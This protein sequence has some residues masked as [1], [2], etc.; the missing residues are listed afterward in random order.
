MA[1]WKSMGRGDGAGFVRKNLLSQGVWSSLAT[2][3][4]VSD[5]RIVGIISGS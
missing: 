3:V 2:V 1:E 4:L 5:R